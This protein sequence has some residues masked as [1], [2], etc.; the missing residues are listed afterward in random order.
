LKSY[1]GFFKYIDVLEDQHLQLDWQ[2]LMIVTAL[3]IAGSLVGGKLAGRLPQN[4]LK[5]SFGI[6]LVVMGI[7]I[8]IRSA[9]E[10]LGL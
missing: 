1:S 4:T 7:Y 2:T 5:K 10:A 9:P 6:F 8:L 3:G